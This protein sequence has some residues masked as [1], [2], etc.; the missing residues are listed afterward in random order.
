VAQTAAQ[1]FDISVWQMLAVLLAGGCV[2]FVGDE[3]IVDPEELLRYASEKQVSILEVVPSLLQTYF[4]IQPESRDRAETPA[5]ANIEQR[6]NLRWLLLTGEALPS[7]LCREWLR[8]YPNVAMLNAYGPTEC[9]DDV[10][11][12]EIEREPDED[13]LQIPIGR[14]LGNLRMYVVDQ[15]LRTVG[16]DI[17]GELLVGGA[18]VGRGY[19]H[20]GGRTAEAFV[21]DVFGEEGQRLYRTGDLVKYLDDGNLVYLGRIDHQVKVRGHR[22]E[23]GEIE[24]KLTA[25][26]SIREAVVIVR[27][28]DEEEKQLIAY[29]VS[30]KNGTV[31]AGALRTHLEQELPEAM[32]PALITEL[33]TMPLTANGKIDRRALAAL[34]VDNQAISRTG[35]GHTFVAAR[36]ET[37]AQ[38][39]LIWEGILHRNPISVHD[40]FFDLGG[41]SLLALRLLARINQQFNSKLPLQAL[42]EGQTIAEMAQLLLPS[43]RTSTAWSPLV[44]LSSPENGGPELAS[45]SLPFFCVHPAT[46]SAFAYVELARHLNRPFYG[47]QSRMEDPLTSIEGMAAAYLPAVRAVQPGGPYLLGGWSMGGLVAYEMAVQLQRDGAEVGLVALMDRADREEEGNTEEALRA[48]FEV[49]VGNVIDGISKN[50]RGEVGLSEEIYQQYFK[51]FVSNFQATK[52]YRA[53]KYD[54]RIMLFSS[55]ESQKM[56]LDETLGWGKLVREV[57]VYQIPGSHNAMLIKPDVALLAEHLRAAIEKI[58]RAQSVVLNLH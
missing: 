16:R 57:D 34:A 44:L 9:S 50:G 45:R 40:K 46:G 21:P 54:G 56:G 20:D 49:V 43:A 29:V 19:L 24:A 42:L 26:P 13:V 8:R 53:K 7:K 37:E 1:S 55:D 39:S 52:D 38:L 22:I 15:W 27:Q 47:L 12:F 11:H 2:D 14:P 10:T 41:H 4:A 5:A 3:T 28:E 23:L 18:G 51:V 35:N 36:N 58:E 31:A 48:M 17:A 32:V 30:E 33:D 25:H 6:G